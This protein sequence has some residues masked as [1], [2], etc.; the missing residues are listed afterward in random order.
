MAVATPDMGVVVHQRTDAATDIQLL[1]NR[2]VLDLLGR[3][4]TLAQLQQL[5]LQGLQAGDSRLHMLDM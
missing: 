2:T 1:Q 4:T 3:R 5:L